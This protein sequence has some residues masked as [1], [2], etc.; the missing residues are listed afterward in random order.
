MT[1]F[2]NN[3]VASGNVIYASDHNTQGSLIANVLNGGI[4]SANLSDSAVTSTKI[5]DT[6]VT[7]AKLLDANVTAPKMNNSGTW[8]SS[9][10]WVSYTP[11]WT[12]LSVGNGTVVARYT[13]IGKTIFARIQLTWGSTTS[14]S[15]SVQV[16]LPVTAQA[17]PGVGPQIGSTK[18]FSGAASFMGPFTQSST[19][20]GVIRWFQVS[21]S[22]IL[23]SNISA[24]SPDTWNTTDEF[25]ITMCYEAA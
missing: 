20:Q 2:V 7:T 15:G 6:A 4:D 16:T 25:H 24:S 17:M 19:T 22:G 8:N 23:E 11:T 12:N 18:L 13:Q 3:D 5:A 1:T 9:W 21:G 10:A 14:V